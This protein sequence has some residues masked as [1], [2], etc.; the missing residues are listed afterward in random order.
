VAT[1]EHWRPSGA[2]CVAATSSR[3]ARAWPGSRDYAVE[4]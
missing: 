1:A 3:S 2:G 4:D